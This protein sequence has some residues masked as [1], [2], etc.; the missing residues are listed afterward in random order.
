[1]TELRIFY[2][3]PGL[4]G[5]SSS[6]SAVRDV[7]ARHYEVV[8]TRLPSGRRTGERLVVSGPGIT[9]QVDVMPGLES[10]D[11]VRD[12]VRARAHVLVVVLDSQ[13]ERLPANRDALAEI[14]KLPPRPMVMQFNK[15]DL[16]PAL[17]VEEMQ[18]ELN[19]HGFP[20]FESVAPRG[21]GT[22]EAFHTAA[23]L[24]AKLAGCSDELRALL[25]TA[26]SPKH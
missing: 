21:V 8:R 25:A 22:M 18:R 14:A 19:P 17:L 24:A 20:A 16:P 4:A 9:L 26:P 6:V 2:D 7:L 23:I 10:V 13:P 15:R 1:M 12:E 11:P 5:R 3:G